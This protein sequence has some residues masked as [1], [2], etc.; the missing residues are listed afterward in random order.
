V[1]EMRS[2]SRRSGFLLFKDD[3]SGFGWIVMIS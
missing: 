2:K 3:P 1:G